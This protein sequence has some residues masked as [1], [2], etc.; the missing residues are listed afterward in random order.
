[1]IH[2]V[3]EAGP[4]PA[5]VTADDEEVLARRVA[6]DVAEIEARFEGGRRRR[7][8]TVADELAPLLQA[9]VNATYE[10]ATNPTPGTRQALD[11]ADAAYTAEHDSWQK[12]ARKALGRA[13]R[14]PVTADEVLHVMLERRA[15]RARPTPDVTGMLS[16]TKPPSASAGRATRTW[17]PS[18]GG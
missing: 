17:C 2:E 16:A 12:Q 8:A 10:W 5:E 9:T 4:G 15:A 1:M 11:R 7:I 3:A 18:C 13:A 6:R 14:E